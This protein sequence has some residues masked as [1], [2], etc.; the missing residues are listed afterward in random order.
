MSGNVS[1]SAV[2]RVT[3]FSAFVSTANL[4]LSLPWFA[5]CS[6]SRSHPVN[7]IHI[8]VNRVRKVVYF[9]PINNSVWLS[10]YLLILEIG[11]KNMFLDEIIS[12]YRLVLRL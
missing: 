7:V 8:T 11:Y 10:F 9:L 3:M 2:A 4:R 12:A 6:F 5:V 1:S